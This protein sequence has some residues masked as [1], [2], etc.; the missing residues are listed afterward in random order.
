[1]LTAA[2]APAARTR[3]EAL[4][5]ADDEASPRRTGE[6]RPTVDES[7]PANGRDSRPV[8]FYSGGRSSCKV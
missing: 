2:T 6:I 8:R 3:L 7:K 1:M 4:L 5:E